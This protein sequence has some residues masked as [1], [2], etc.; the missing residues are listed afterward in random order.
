MPLKSL[1]GRQ[2]VIVPRDINA[3]GKRL[4]AADRQCS[5]ASTGPIT[6]FMSLP[7]TTISE[8][9]ISPSISVPIAGTAAAAERRRVWGLQAW[10]LTA[11]LFLVPL[12]T[13]WPATFHEFGLRDDYSNIREAHEEPGVI[14]KFCASHARPVYGWL[15]QSTFGQTETVQALQWLRFV[16]ALLLGAISLVSFRGLRALGWSFDASLCFALLLALIPSEQVIASWAVGWPYAAT[17][18]L[19]FGAF[20]T[21]EG[22]LNMGLSGGRGRAAGQWAVAIGLMVVGALIYQ[23]SVL[24]YV[25]PLAAALIAQRHR[26]LAQTARWAGVH[27]GF[28][29]GTLGLAYALI[30]V[31]YANGIF[32]KSGRIAFEHDWGGKIG[33]FLQQTLPNALSLFVLNDNNHRDHAMY[34]TCAAAVSAILIVGA[35]LEWR[36][37]GRTRGIVWL[38]A[39]L[40]LPVLACSVSLIASERY[41]TY[42]TIF[43][44]TAVLLCFLVASIG[45]LTHNLGPVARRALA[46][47]V[48][49]TA[50]LT[51]Q[52]HA[53]SLIAVPQGNEWG[54]IKSG[55]KQVHLGGPRPRIFAIMS[56]PADISTATIYHD[57]FGSLSS[58]SDWV[59]KE[60]FKRALHEL[61]PE[62]ANLDAL[63]DFSLGPTLPAEQHY[64]VIIDLHR[65]RRFYTD[66]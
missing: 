22:A 43:A 27:L 54:L 19:A 32:V 35:C 62:I 15:L 14:V 9:S 11:T 40:G 48:L 3:I 57:E 41:A 36:R 30:S 61:H 29:V 17:A 64:D 51:A 5:S 10:I 4:T 56:T 59:P 44:M 7:E 18:L 24:F 31:L 20:F 1:P 49:I 6:P 42:R 16:S 47:L 21:V 34:L 2:A 37:Y 28:V 66:N 50:F 45:A 55:A 39:L 46:G 58:N 60:M 65:L 8:S 53:Y 63:Y 33:W 26:T 12:V 52:H 38:T 25:V 13:Y 23:S